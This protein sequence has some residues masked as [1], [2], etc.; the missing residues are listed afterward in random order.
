VIGKKDDASCDFLRSRERKEIHGESKNPQQATVVELRLKCLHGNVT[1][2]LMM[3]KRKKRKR[4]QKREKR[5]KI[6][7]WRAEGEAWRWKTNL[8]GLASWI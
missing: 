2:L 8:A 5:R 1:P 3:K 6:F 7:V 4:N